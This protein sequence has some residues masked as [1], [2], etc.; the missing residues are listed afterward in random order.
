MPAPNLLFLYTDEQAF[1]TLAAYG[2][3]AIQMPHLNRLAEESFVFEQAYVSQPVCT[4]SRSTLL[5]GLWPHT[6]GCTENN[7][8]LPDEV[9]CFPEMLEPGKYATA[10]VG[11]WH[12]GDE[13]FSQHGFQEWVSVEDFYQEY[14]REGRDRTAKS[15][16]HHFLVQNGFSPKAGHTFGRDESA[17]LPEAYGKAAFVGREAARFIQANRDQPFVLYVNF[18]EPHMPFFGPRDRQYPAEDMPLPSNFFNP[19]SAQQPLKTQLLREYY[20]RQ[21]EGGQ[22]LETPAQWQQLI[23]NYWGLC[24]LVDTHVGHLL[25]TLKACNLWNQTIIV[26]T[27]DHGDMMGSHQLLGKCVMFEEAVRVPLLLRLPAQQGGKR[28]GGPS[29]Q[30][31]LVPTL[32]DLMDQP[33]PRHLPGKS[34]RSVL[35]RANPALTEDVF[36]EWNGPNNGMGDKRGQVSF[37]KWLLE[38]ASEETIRS[39]C[40]DAIWT[41]ITPAGWKMN[42]SSRGEHELYNL[43]QDGDETHNLVGQPECQPIRHSLVNKIRHWRKLTGDPIPGL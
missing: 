28:V 41:V 12:L 9:A 37:P 40:G 38:L 2:N 7:V 11:K 14:Y 5:T 23:A 10:H 4:A 36:I 18:F 32:L 29:S 34:W 42:F 24:S 8:P 19:P 31:D 13:I 25:E 17:R 39:A 15:S 30:I 27:S 21:G 1:K 20:R 6:S 22:P 3:P 43:V 16:Y 26:F 33:I 35:E